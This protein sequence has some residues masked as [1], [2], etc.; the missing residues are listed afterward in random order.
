MIAS[1]WR[2]RRGT[3]S[4][5]PCSPTASSAGASGSSTSSCCWRS[6]ASSS[7]SPPTTATRAPCWRGCS[8]SC[9]CRC[10][11]SSPTS[12]SGATS[13]AT[14]RG[15]ARS[16]RRWTPSPSE[17]LGAGGG[18]QHGVH[19]G[20]GRPTSPATPGARIE[21]VGLHRG[22]RGAAAGRHR[23][24]LHGRLAEVPRPARGD[25]DG[26]E[27]HPPHVPH[28]GAGRADRQGQGR[29]AR[30]PQ[31]R[32]QGAHPLRLAELHQLQEGRAQGARR[33]RRRRRALLQAPAADQLPQPHEDGDHR[34]QERVQRR[35]EHGPGVHRRRPALRRLARHLVP[36][37]RPGG[38]ALPHALRL[39]LAATTAARRTWP[40][41]YMPPAAEHHRHEG[42]PV[43]VLHS[44]VAD[45]VQDDPRRVHHRAH[46]TRAS[47]SGSSRRTSCPTSR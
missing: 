4:S 10:S 21:A 1:S 8:S 26:R 33:R 11:A 31:G 44:S 17:S 39:H 15:G 35:H 18:G 12:S 34:R 2:V 13:A 46:S 45:H 3:S 47:A 9:C 19:R 38:R 43:Q 40:P 23:G 14:H 30:P 37:Q 16:W 7:C 27:V 6:P 22:R 25:G 20:R 5:R 24:H 29:P 36:P 28:L 32:R 41:S 42:T